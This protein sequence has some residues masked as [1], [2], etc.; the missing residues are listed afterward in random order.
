MESE[1][2]K[3]MKA[4][5]PAPLKNSNPNAAGSKLTPG[6]LTAVPSASVPQQLTAAQQKLASK[7][8]EAQSIAEQ[9]LA[10]ELQ[11]AVDRKVALQAKRD[12]RIRAI[13]ASRAVRETRRRDMV[14][15]FEK[16]SGVVS[17]TRH[18]H[19]IAIQKA[20]YDGERARLTSV[21]VRNAAVLRYYERG[22]LL[23]DADVDGAVGDN[24]LVASFQAME[25]EIT[26]QQASDM[27]LK[28]IQVLASVPGIERVCLQKQILKPAAGDAA[29]FTACPLLWTSVR[30]AFIAYLNYGSRVGCNALFDVV[31]YLVAVGE[32]TGDLDRSTHDAIATDDAVADY[33]RII[34]SAPPTPLA[35]LF[36]DPALKA[37]PKRRAKLVL[38]LQ[39]TLS[40]VLDIL[41]R[42]FG[43]PAEH[44][45]IALFGDMSDPSRR[46]SLAEFLRAC[47]FGASGLWG[48]EGES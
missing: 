48:A 17:K 43:P 41:V 3:N 27:I 25:C 36:F 30:D 21:A 5:S 31:E 46:I 16:W 42:R 15:Q 35:H 32:R 13:E 2:L 34:S 24:D 4:A 44:N 6:Q 9:K 45:L 37:R 38:Q 20:F 11:E 39:A 14:L 7:L 1:F 23:L 33:E 19:L 22:W 8:Q 10:K 29:N 18:D 47:E 28:T 26:Q 40:A 12:E